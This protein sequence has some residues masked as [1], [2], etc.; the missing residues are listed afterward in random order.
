M[1]IIRTTNIKENLCDTCPK[2]KNFPVCCPDDLEFGKGIG[3]DNII[4]CSQCISEYS[5]TIYP[6]EI[7]KLKS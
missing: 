6:A 3:N 2:N 1:R 4:A 5:E 7:S